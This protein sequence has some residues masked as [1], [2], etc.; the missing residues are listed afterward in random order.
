MK[1]LYNE[2][3]ALKD[4]EFAPDWLATFG[5]EILSKKHIPANTPFWYV[6]DEELQTLEGIPIEAWEVEGEPDGVGG[7][8]KE[9]EE[10]FTTKLKEWQNGSSKQ[11]EVKAD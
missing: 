2:N 1:V 4:M 9:E 11:F 7:L 6:T 5:V 3:A 8:S 10:A